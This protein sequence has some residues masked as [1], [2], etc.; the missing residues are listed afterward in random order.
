MTHPFKFKTIL[1][2]PW[3][4]I[5]LEKESLRTTHRVAKKSGSRRQKTSWIVFSSRIDFA[6]YAHNALISQ[7]HGELQGCRRAQVF[8]YLSVIWY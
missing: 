1:Q 6:A 4:S 3:L 2:D 8:F 7:E 5:I